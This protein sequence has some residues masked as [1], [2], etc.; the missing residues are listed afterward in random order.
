MPCC[1]QDIWDVLATGELE[2]LKTVTPY[3]FDWRS[4]RCP[5]TQCTPLQEIINGCTEQT[6]AR[7]LET[8]AWL[9]DQGADPTCVASEE[10]SSISFWEDDDPIGTEV[11]VRCAGRSAISTA[12]RLREKMEKADLGDWEEE[13]AFLTQL[14]ALYSFRGSMAS[15]WH[16]SQQVQHRTSVNTDVVDRWEKVMQHEASH[17]T[18][19]MTAD[20]PRTAHAVMLKL[21]S[22]V[23]KAALESGMVEARER[24][25]VVAD[26]PGDAVALFLEL[27]YTGGCCAETD[28]S[29][30]I[31]ALE[32]AHRWQVDDVVVMLRNLLE[33]LLSDSSFEQIAGAA[34]R[35][36]LKELGRACAYFAFNSPTIQEKLK[37]GTLSQS[38]LKLLGHQGDT[39]AKKKRRML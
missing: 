24:S 26:A 20:G 18:V 9:I 30:A 29:L 7:H 6:R 5:K 17:D 21:A 11:T 27:T 23:L 10:A 4:E 3:G 39:Q 32:L 13:I 1:I 14:V 36:H 33:T 31:S 16:S 2:A 34:Q 38:V 28:A 12:L 19:L 37:R 35:M 22:P 25:I 15:R 8:A